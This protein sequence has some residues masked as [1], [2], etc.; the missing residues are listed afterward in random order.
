MNEN[1]IQCTDSLS[2]SKTSTTPKHADDKAL[3]QS[4]GKM[5]TDFSFVS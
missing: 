2:I 4:G 5:N 1:K 3:R